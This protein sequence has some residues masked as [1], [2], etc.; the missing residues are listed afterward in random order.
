MRFETR[1]VVGYREP[2][3]WTIVVRG[4][5]AIRRRAILTKEHGRD[6]IV[7]REDDDVANVV[8]LGER[9]VVQK[10]RRAVLGHAPCE[11]N[12]VAGLNPAQRMR[13]V[14]ANAIRLAR[15]VGRHVDDPTAV[16][17]L[18]KRVLVSEAG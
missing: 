9:E 17:V 7:V 15:V 10:A 2:P 1:D 3:V 8:E 6:V 14:D 18:G 11:R 16:V 4:G 12:V 5:L 13:A